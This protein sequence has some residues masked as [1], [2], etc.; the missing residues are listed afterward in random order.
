M[1]LAT[2]LAA[3]GAGAAQA[4]VV[5]EANGARAEERWGGELGLGYRIQIGQFSITPAVGALISGSDEDRFYTDTFSNGQSRC[6]ERSTGQFADDSDCVE[7]DARPYG[8]LEA[9]YRVGGKGVELGGG[10]RISKEFVPYGTLAI[11]LGGGSAQI[12]GNAGPDYFAA[13]LRFSF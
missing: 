13:G 5:V 3:G 7:L 11:P 4:Q 12:K 8:R 6:R 10:V 1:M 2:V 9:T